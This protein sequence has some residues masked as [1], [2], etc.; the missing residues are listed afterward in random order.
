MRQQDLECVLWIDLFANKPAVHADLQGIM[1]MTLDAGAELCRILNENETAKGCEE[2]VV[3]LKKD[4]P[5]AVN[6][7]Q[8]VS[9]L[10]LAGLMPAKEANK[11]ISVGETKDFST[12]YGYYML[13]ANPKTGDYLGA[14]NNIRSYWGAMLDLGATTRIKTGGS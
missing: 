1:V 14:I 5:D 10:T 13:Q 12:F 3:K 9:L 6:N 7:K 2:T 8:A 11:I 4:V